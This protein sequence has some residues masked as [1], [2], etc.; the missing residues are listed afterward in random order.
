M[1]TTPE[2]QLIDDVIIPKWANNAQ[3]FLLKMRAA[4]ESDYVSATLSEWIDLTFG[5]KQTGTSA[6]AADN[7]FYYLT[8]EQNVNFDKAMSKM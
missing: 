4:F 2:G 5:F 1:G 3:D 6:I 8:Y 7:V